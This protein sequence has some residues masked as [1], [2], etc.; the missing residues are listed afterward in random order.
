VNI[1]RRLIKFSLAART[2]FAA[3]LILGILGGILIIY[4]AQ[5]I[6]QIVGRVFMLGQTLNS[7]TPAMISLLLIIVFRA[8][9][10]LLAEGAAG[11]A[12]IQIKHQLRKMM[13]SHL[14][15]LG[16]A[17]VQGESSGE[18]SGVVVDGIEAVDAY[19]SQYLPQLILA[20]AIPTAILIVVFPLD[21]LT[22]VILLITAPLIPLFMVLIG[23]AAERLTLRQWTAMSRL[24]A[25]F[26][27]T[28]QG[29]VTLKLLGRS[30][31]REA[32]IVA[33]SERYRLATMQVLRVSFLSAFTL[34][35]V[36]TISTAVV[37]V[38]IGLRLLSGRIDFEQGF[39]LLLLAPDFYGPIRLLGQR[40][41]AG[42]AGVSAAKRIFDILEVSAPKE[43]S[44]LPAVKKTPIEILKDTLI[45]E[46]VT[47]TYPS[48]E[49]ASVYEV[50]FS[51]APEQQVAVVGTSGA[52]K[53]TLA[54]LLLRFIQPQSGIIRI[55]ERGIEGIDLSAWRRQV[56]WVPQH[57]QLFNT[58]LAE[59]IRLAKPDASL[60]EIRK[61]ARLAFLDDWV[62]HLADGYN[63]LA[64]EGGVRLSGGQAQRL[65]LARAF[66]KDAPFLVMDEPT[67]H[68]DPE[69]E[70]L[71]EETTRRLCSGRRVLLIAHRL[72][73]IFR[74]DMI[75]HLDAGCVVEWGNHEDLYRQTGRYYNLVNA[76]RG[77]VL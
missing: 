21:L 2:A 20:A 4:Q 53:S 14:F 68:L 38:E 5:T 24:N 73:T 36:A 6:S 67:A 51:I 1:N 63:T 62:V 30:Q 13:T 15:A 19:F 29:L 70:A 25:F 16:P 40:F 44:V 77:Q 31:N 10:I 34:E 12:A 72:P 41:H 23:K 46:Q 22:A 66:L 71:L 47:Y 11:T 28:L 32:E 54:M 69:Q 61:A 49:N 37:A 17:Y 52:G 55:G 9:V 74:S 45:F 64:G 8:L 42:M 27:D 56:A 7:V 43:V 75:L 26:L 3:A 58:T 35:L 50:S 60:E 76:F 57:P 65:A 39:F 59:N 48:R 18:L 33:V